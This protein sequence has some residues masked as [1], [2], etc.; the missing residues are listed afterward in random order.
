[1]TVTV[2]G[3][4]SVNGI[5]VPVLEIAIPVGTTHVKVIP[6][7]DYRVYDCDGYWDE[8]ADNLAVSP[9]WGDFYTLTADGGR[10]IDYVIKF[11]EAKEEPPVVT[12]P[13]TVTVNGEAVE[14][15]SLGEREYLSSS[16]KDRYTKPVY[17]VK[18]TEGVD[19]VINQAETGD[20]ASGTWRTFAMASGENYSA[21]YPYTTNS[22]I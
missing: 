12:V 1:M 19:F 5:D 16:W 8:N 22:S 14:V 15:T 4:Q 10:T 3:T 17:T 20:G 13:I 9:S 21:D 2:N 18:I 11:A 7:G 6:S